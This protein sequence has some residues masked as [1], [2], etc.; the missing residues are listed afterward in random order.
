MVQSWLNPAILGTNLGLNLVMVSLWG[1]LGAAIATGLSFV[2]GTMYLRLL[3]FQ[4]LK[5]RF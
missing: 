4:H 1:V 5:V 3:V 2:A